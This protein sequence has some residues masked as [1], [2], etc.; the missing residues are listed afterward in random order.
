MFY[1]LK[2]KGLKSMSKNQADWEKYQMKI[3]E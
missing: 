3:W 2:K 1:V